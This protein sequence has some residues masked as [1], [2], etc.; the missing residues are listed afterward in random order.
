MPPD[1]PRPPGRHRTVYSTGRKRL[2]GRKRS[3]VPSFAPHSSRSTYRSHGRGGRRWPKRVLIGAVVVVVLL[4][5]M[6]VAGYAYIDSE[7]GG[8]QRVAVTGLTP[9]KAGQPLDILLIGSDSRQCETTA[10]QAKAFGSKAT[11]TGQRADT[12]IVARFLGSGQVELFSIPRDTWVPIAGTNGSAKINAAFN[13]GP[14]QLVATIQQNFKIPINHVAMVNFCGFPAMVN[15]LGGITMDFPDPV[16]DPY[17]GLDVRQT[18]CQTVDGTEALALVRSRHL[19]YYADGKWNYDGMSD[20]SRIQRQQAFFR[21][22]L[23][24]VRSAFPDPFTVN[25]FVNAAVQGLAVDKSFSSSSMIAL[26]WHDHSLGASSLVTSLL[27]TTESVIDGE[28]VLLPAPTE[29]HAVI[30]AFLAGNTATFESALG[31]STASPGHT[32]LV[33]STVII[34]HLDE[35]WNPYPC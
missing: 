1:L 31:R 6:S 20:F 35:P 28:D 7:L 9:A 34:G 2:F 8:I 12:I 21:A 14:S 24:K 16:T 25:D 11:Q 15:A 23:D 29:D 30:Q 10:A 33:S 32:S 18:G 17:T 13:S 5:V 27:P 3:H 19:S 4:L 26:G 22:L